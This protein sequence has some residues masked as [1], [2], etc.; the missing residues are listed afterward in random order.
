MF[1]FL[2][3][4]VVYLLSSVLVICVAMWW[5]TSFVSSPS[6]H[7]SYLFRLIST[8]R[9]FLGVYN[10]GSCCAGWI[11]SIRLL[12]VWILASIWIV[13]SAFCRKLL[14]LSKLGISN[15]KCS[16]LELT[17]ITISPQ[18]T[19]DVTLSSVHTPAFTMHTFC[20]SWSNFSM[21]M[22]IFGF[23]QWCARQP[24]EGYPQRLWKPMTTAEIKMFFAA[25]WHVR[26]HSL[27]NTCVQ[28]SVTTLNSGKKSSFYIQG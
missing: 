9:C 17:Q 27:K 14:Q 19:Q 20:G 26:V 25:H 1:Q 11:V 4:L 7:P 24:L 10:I 18:S 22:L 5:C 16:T 6:G 13:R 28:S 2:I 23:C 21:C 3:W 8:Q 12:Q 15:W